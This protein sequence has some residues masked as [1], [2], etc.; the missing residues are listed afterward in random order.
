MN[1]VFRHLHMSSDL[2]CEFIAVFSRLEYALKATRFSVG[3]DDGVSAN[4]D[5]FANEANAIFHEID[6]EVLETSVKYLFSRPPRKQVLEDRQRL[7]FRE[8]EI[9]H[10]QRP[11]QQILLMVRTIRNNLFHGGKY[12]PFGEDEP[13]RN[14]ALV[15]HSLIVLNTC[16]LLLDDVRECYEV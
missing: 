9:D 6:S 12:L 13:G 7:N 10:A 5:R 14:E 16:A 3:N 2:V 15:Q 4:W 8:F 11:L 1:Q